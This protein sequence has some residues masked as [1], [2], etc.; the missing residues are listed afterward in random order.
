MKEEL[1]LIIYPPFSPIVLL[2]KKTYVPGLAIKEVQAWS[3]PWRCR[4]T[5]MNFWG[6]QTPAVPFTWL[7][8]IQWFKMNF[9]VQF[10]YTILGI[11][12]FVK[13]Y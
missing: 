11:V 4:E 9:C 13:K 6:Q 2:H 7:K 10:T 5:V 3:S 12:V 8:I 1:L